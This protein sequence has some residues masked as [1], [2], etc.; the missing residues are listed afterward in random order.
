MNAKFL[1]MICIKKMAGP[2]EQANHTH[3]SNVKE[4]SNLPLDCSALDLEK[5][6]DIG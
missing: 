3:T 1:D 2:F 6:A 4:P 5:E